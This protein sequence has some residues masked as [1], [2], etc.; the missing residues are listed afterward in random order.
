MSGGAAEMECNQGHR[1]PS[2]ASYV[3][4][5]VSRGFRPWLLTIAPPGLE[6]RNFKTCAWRS[7]RA[8]RALKAA[9]GEIG[10]SA[11]FLVMQ[12]KSGGAGLVPTGFCFAAVAGFLE[13]SPQ[14]IHEI[15][16]AAAGLADRR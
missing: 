7:G 3:V 8:R 12:P 10:F 6:M 2:G 15:D 14:G 1:R 11:S 13:T 4:C 16:D 5:P 9:S